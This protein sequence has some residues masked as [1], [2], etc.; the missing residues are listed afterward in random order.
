MMNDAGQNEELERSYGKVL[1]YLVLTGFVLL[2]L[3]FFLYAFGVL[4]A[5]MDAERVP[6][7]WAMPADEAQ[8]LMGRPPF[9]GWVTNLHRA[10]L[11]SL[12]SLAFLTAVTPLAFT[13]LLALFL[14]HKN[15]PYAA[16]VFVEM[17]IL[18]LAA[19]GLV[20]G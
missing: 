20:G 13:F 15:V 5:Y 2:F 17:L 18:I 6:E 12:G 8:E 16:M 3:M 11:L 9:W 7:I 14:K 4:P 19:S 10:D 1:H